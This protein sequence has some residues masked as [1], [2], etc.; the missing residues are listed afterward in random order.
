MSCS[1]SP[2]P[3]VKLFSAKKKY[4]TKNVSEVVEGAEL[5]LLTDAAVEDRDRVDDGGAVGRVRGEHAG[6]GAARGR[7]CVGW[8]RVR[9]VLIA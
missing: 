2:G 7:A 3:T 4:Q 5:T 1:I 9:C 8:A 6:R